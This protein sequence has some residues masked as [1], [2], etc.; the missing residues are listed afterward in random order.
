MPIINSIGN[1]LKYIGD[2]SLFIRDIFFWTLSGKRRIKDTVR[3][4][5]FIGMDSVGLVSLISFFIGII[6]GTQS[7]LWIQG[8]IVVILIIFTNS[9]AVRSHEL[10]AI[11]YIFISFATIVG[12]LIGDISYFVQTNVE[13]KINL[14]IHKSFLN[15]FKAN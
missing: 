15:L 2:I 8:L 7:P 4:I 3:E 1:F 10:G 12:M 11:S 14:D 6:I 9:D 13:L 5:I